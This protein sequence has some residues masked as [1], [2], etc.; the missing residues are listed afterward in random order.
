MKVHTSAQKSILRTVHSAL[1]VRIAHL[2]HVGHKV[3]AN[4][5]FVARIFRSRIDSRLSGRSQKSAPLGWSLTLLSYDLGA[6]CTYPISKPAGIICH[7]NP[8]AYIL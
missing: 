8:Y 5:F 1:N 2:A 3:L 6:I 7:D 4:F